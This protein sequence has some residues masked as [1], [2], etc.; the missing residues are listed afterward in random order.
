M[1]I[2]S[3]RW[4]IILLGIG[5]FFL[6]I[7]LGYL[8]HHVWWSL[9]RLWPVFII[10]I[11]IE[12]IFQ[13]GS[14]RF[15]AVLS[16]LV[17]AAAFVYAAF[18][19]SDYNKFYW[20]HTFNSN[21]YDYS[22]DSKRF[23]FE[24]DDSLKSLKV[25]FDFTA[26]QI[27]IGP[28]SR[29]LF[30]G[31][32][33]YWREPPTCKLKRDLYTA[34]IFVNSEENDRWIFG[35]RK[36]DNNDARVFIGDYLPVEIRLKSTAASIDMDLADII[37]DNV[38]IDAGASDIGIKLGCRS[39]EVSVKIDSGA[40]KVRLSLPYEMG[41][42]LK[43]DTIVSP[44]NFRGLSLRK[45]AGGYESDNYATSSCKAEIDLDSGV[46]LVEIDAY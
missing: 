21:D 22:H 35:N 42:K 18:A 27:W 6:A 36:H 32:F 15:L 1:K 3:V 11:G 38:R 5:L 40:S 20:R 9:I 46:S 45:V 39:K 33:E 24:R 41:I 31:D 14:L 30:S 16:P 37:V 29:S 7:N 17:I 10:A 4:G 34:E 44:T 25:N 19:D 13:R 8:T 26:G 23:E 43:M 2:S 12:M 28:T